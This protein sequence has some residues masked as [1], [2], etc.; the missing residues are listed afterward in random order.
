[1]LQNIKLLIFAAASAAALAP[2]TTCYQQLYDQG[3]DVLQRREATEQR[4]ALFFVARDK[5]ADV[6]PTIIREAAE[7]ESPVLGPLFSETV[8]AH[9]S[10]AS[11]VASLL[12]SRLADAVIPREPLEEALREAL[13]GP[14]TA[15][16]LA[17]DLLAVVES[18]PAAPGLLATFLNFKGFHALS[19]YRAAHALWARDDPAA[20]QL[21]LLLQGRASSAF[22]VDIHPGATIGS[23][24]FID[25]ATSVVI[26]E[27]AT[28]GDD[29]YVLHGV[30]LGATGKV[31]N[32]RR[33][34]T[35]GSGCTLGSLCSVLGPITVGDGAT[36]GACATVTKNVEAGATV[37]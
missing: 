35:I 8:Y 18:D 24:V 9:K 16:A 36:I 2:T 19:T 15:N 28:L 5:K 21:A 32:G 31:R 11:G 6:W 1:M 25:H 23:G 17:R 33:H 4:L 37:V 34:P 13:A 22:G 12:A 10:L 26:G 27:Q 7:S 14:R 29:C 30:T 20:R 3:L